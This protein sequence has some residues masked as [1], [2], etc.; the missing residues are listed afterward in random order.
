MTCYSTSKLTEPL[1]MYIEKQWDLWAEGDDSEC[2]T[3]AD[4]DAALASEQTVYPVPQKYFYNMHT[5][6]TWK[7]QVPRF[8]LK[9]IRLPR[10]KD[11]STTVKKIT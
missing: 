1:G 3:T 4:K 6:E 8:G 11:W 2:V 7:H 5:E 9:A 10:L